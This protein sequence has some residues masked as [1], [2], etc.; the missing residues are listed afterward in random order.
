MPTYYL[1]GLMYINGCN[2]DDRR[3]LIPDGSNDPG[4]QPPLDATMLV[5]KDHW[6]ADT[7][8]VSQQRTR[9]LTVDGQQKEFFEFVLKKRSRVSVPYSGGPQCFKLEKGLPRAQKADFE[10]T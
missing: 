10:P 1:A 4:I 2:G 9:I 8:G 5:A 3:V 7:F 6:R